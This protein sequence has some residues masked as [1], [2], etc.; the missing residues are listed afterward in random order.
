MPTTSGRSRG[1]QGVR[2]GAAGP[3]GEHLPKVIV[4]LLTAL[5]VVV[6]ALVMTTQAGKST[7]PRSVSC[8]FTPGY[9]R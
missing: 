4:G 8:F 7:P 5:I 6:L 9:S 3:V 2:S 1:R